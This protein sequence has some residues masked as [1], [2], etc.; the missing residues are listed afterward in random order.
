L[1]H[2]VQSR[3]QV[4]G[5]KSLQQD[6]GCRE[7]EVTVR[8]QVAG[9]DSLQQDT[10]CKEKEFTAEHRMQGKRVYSRLQFRL[11]ERESKAAE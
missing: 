8:M 11:M 9:R 3:I 7:K 10:D 4:A 6:A 5:K 2:E 1:Q